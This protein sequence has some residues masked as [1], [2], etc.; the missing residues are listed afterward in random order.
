MN[1]VGNYYELTDLQHHLLGC[2]R[3]VL[4]RSIHRTEPVVHT[5]GVAIDVKVIMIRVKE[6]I[7]NVIVVSLK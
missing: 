2:F 4:L 3:G 7:L 1:V 6:R 5:L